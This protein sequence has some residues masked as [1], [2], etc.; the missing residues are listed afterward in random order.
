VSDFVVLTAVGRD[1][2]GI[3]AAVSDLLW[4]AGC[5]IEDASMTLLRGEFAILLIARRPAELST[6]ALAARLR[7]LESRSGLQITVKELSAQESEPQAPTERP[8]VLH[9]YGKDRQGIVSQISSLLAACGV[10][11]TDVNTRVLTASTP[12]VYVMMLEID[13]PP[14]ADEAELRAAL[15]ET[16]AGLGVD[17]SLQAVDAEAL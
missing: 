7:S 8:Y 10:N 13:L 12:P 17:V 9:V 5:N 16:A 6:E 3:V 11:I 15:A 14:A 1:Q 4:Q 2:P